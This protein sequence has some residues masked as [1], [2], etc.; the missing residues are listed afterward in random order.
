MRSKWCN[1]FAPK[2]IGCT[3]RSNEWMGERKQLACARKSYFKM[4]KKGSEEQYMW[5]CKTGPA[6]LLYKWPAP[7]DTRHEDWTKKLATYFYTTYC[8]YTWFSILLY[9]WPANPDTRHEDW[10]KKLATYFYTSYCCY[11]WFSIWLSSLFVAWGTNR[12]LYASLQNFWLRIP[13][14]AGLSTFRHD[15]P[16]LMWRI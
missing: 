12:Q 13:I 8:C 1:I 9:K 10:T 4:N 3:F 11:T 7:P 6:I 5:L 14:L 16:S 2:I 15:L